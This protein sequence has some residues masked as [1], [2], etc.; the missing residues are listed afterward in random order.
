LYDKKDTTIR[1]NTL[2]SDLK[3]GEIKWSKEGYKEEVK[4]PKSVQLEKVFF[5]HQEYEEI[6]STFND[7]EKISPDLVEI[8][9]YGKTTNNKTHIS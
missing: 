3:V 2:T 7:W 8:G 6:I 9:V 4:K 5:G 1:T